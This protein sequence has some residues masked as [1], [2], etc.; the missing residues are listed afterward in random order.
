M[1]LLVCE[2]ELLYYLGE[3]VL[4]SKCNISPAVLLQLF[5]SSANLFFFFQSKQSQTANQQ[6]YVN[7]YNDSPVVLDWEDSVKTW[8]IFE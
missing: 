8:Q 6:K 3:I 4:F 1:Y 5:I 2:G 7:L